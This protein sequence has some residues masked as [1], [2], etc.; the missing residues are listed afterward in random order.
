[1]LNYSLIQS[2][3]RNRMFLIR[4][5]PLAV[6]SEVIDEVTNLLIPFTPSLVKQFVNIGVFRCLKPRSITPISIPVYTTIS[7]GSYGS[8]EAT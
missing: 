3:I 8:K 5:T 4:L 2:P 7:R 1:M 6:F